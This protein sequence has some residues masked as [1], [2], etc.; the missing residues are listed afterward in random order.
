MGCF[1]PMFFSFMRSSKIGAYSESDFYPTRNL[2]TQDVAIDNLA[3]PQILKVC[4]KC[5]K[6]DPF[7]EGSD[8]FL[9]RTHDELCPVTAMLTW[10]VKRNAKPAAE[11]PLFVLQSGAPLTCNSFVAHFKE[12]LMAVHIDPT[13]FSRH[14]FRIGAA[15]TA[16]RQGLPKSIIKRL[17]RWKSTP[18]QRYIKPPTTHLASLASSISAQDQSHSSAQNH[19]HGTPS[20]VVDGDS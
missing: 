7:R 20:S 16:S 15:T 19:S 4:L 12:A 8:I 2:N 3:N 10:L 6:T 9:A 17:G 14:S 13:G 1:Y 18:Y 5:S 11:G